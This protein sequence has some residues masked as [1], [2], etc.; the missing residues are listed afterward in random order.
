MGGGLG[1]VAAIGGVLLVIV[2]AYAILRNRQRS[3]ADIRQTEQATKD[4]YA[5]TDRQDQ[6]SDP[7]KKDF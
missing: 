3:S 7:D 1:L 2:L 5:R 6:A 4:L